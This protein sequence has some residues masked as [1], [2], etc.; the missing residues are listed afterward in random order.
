MPGLW[1]RSSPGISSG[2]S[3][4]VDLATA[5]VY[6]RCMRTL[7]SGATETSGAPFL[8]LNP[9]SFGRAKQGPCPS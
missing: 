6:F 4:A 9:M 1:H 8:L 7:G 3:G 5:V 2:A